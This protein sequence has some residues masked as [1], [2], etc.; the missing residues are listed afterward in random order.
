MAYSVNQRTHEIGIRIALGAQRRDV[1]RLVINQG[2]TMAAIGVAIGMA[3]SFAMTR[4]MKTLLFEV[5]ATDFGTFAIIGLAL[6]GVVSLAC[7]LPAR[8][9]A[10][11]D[12]MV[13]LRYE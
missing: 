3:V 8:K 9:A 11:V 1:L 4:L 6:A 7:Y 12:P 10:R 2:M 5:S 13:A